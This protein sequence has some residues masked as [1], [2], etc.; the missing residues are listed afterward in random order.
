MTDCTVRPRSDVSRCSRRMKRVSSS[1]STN[2][3]M[4]IRRRSVRVGEDQDAFDDDRAARMGGLRFGTAGVPREV[5]DRQFDRPPAAQL[6]EWRT[7][8][9]V[10]SES[11]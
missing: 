5:V 9:S 2:T 3:L 11:G 7:S 6:V 10:S 4:S 1:V 8:R